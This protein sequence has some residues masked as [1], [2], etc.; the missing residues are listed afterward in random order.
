MLLLPTHCPHCHA[1]HH[2]SCWCHAM[3]PQILLLLAQIQLLL[4]Q[5][6]LLLAHM[7]LLLAQMLLLLA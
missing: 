5:T 7:L 1:E 4:A 3:Q 6:L 2:Q